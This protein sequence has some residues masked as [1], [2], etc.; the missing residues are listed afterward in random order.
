MTIRNDDTRKLVMEFLKSDCSCPYCNVVLDTKDRENLA[1][2]S[3]DHLEPYSRSFN[4]DHSNLVLSCVRC[5]QLKNNL[6]SFYTFKFPQMTKISKEELNHIDFHAKH[7][8]IIPL[9]EEVRVLVINNDM[10]SVE[11]CM[12]YVL[13]N[14][15][16]Y[17]LGRKR[18]LNMIKKIL[19]FNRHPSFV[20]NDATIQNLHRNKKYDSSNIHSFLIKYANFLVESLY[21]NVKKTEET[22]QKHP[23]Y[24]VKVQ[25]EE[26]KNE[27]PTVSQLVVD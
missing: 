17:S 23:Y 3:I 25:M 2:L 5:N 26:I 11:Y 19:V 12:K 18:L 27:L 1:Y 14:V 15:P 20:R 7:S 22:V 16:E 21:K 13:E 24:I 4:N 10:D 8:W 9:M 6:D